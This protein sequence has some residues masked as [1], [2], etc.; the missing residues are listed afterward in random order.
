MPFEGGVCDRV[1]FVRWTGPPTA[2]DVDRI[3][4]EVESAARAVG[5][6]PCVLVNSPGRSTPPSSEVRKHLAERAPQWM[7][8]AASVELVILGDS[9]GMQLLR[10]VIRGMVAA[11]TMRGGAAQRDVVRIHSSI[12][13]AL[14]AVSEG[15]TVGARALEENARARGFLP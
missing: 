6:L 7:K 2:A 10:T 5:P 12:E 15:K 9:I 3:V 8:S 4:S 13:A 11:G 1:Y 14:R